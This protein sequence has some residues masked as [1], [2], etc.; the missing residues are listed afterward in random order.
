MH[1]HCSSPFE[2]SDKKQYTIA[3]CSV[4]LA[5]VTVLPQTQPP[6][7]SLTANPVFQNNCAK[8]HGKTAEGHRFGGPSLVSPITTGISADKL[9]YIIANG[10]IPKFRMPKFGGKLTSEEIDMLV[11]QIQATTKK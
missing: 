11:Q 8:C 3:V 5:P 7:T 4:F 10:K 2:E 9:H 1:L 6:A